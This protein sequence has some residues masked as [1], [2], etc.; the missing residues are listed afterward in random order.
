MC[1]SDVQKL[2]SYEKGHKYYK[3]FVY[4]LTQTFSDPMGENFYPYLIYLY[5]TKY[6]KIDMC[7]SCIHKH[8][9]KNA[10]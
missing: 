9:P 10:L 3:N 5:F 6:N 7:N 1:H 4:S 2:V 8:A